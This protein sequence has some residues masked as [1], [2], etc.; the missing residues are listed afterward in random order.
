MFVTGTLIIIN[1]IHEFRWISRN[2]THICRIF[3]AMW[4]YFVYVHFEH[5]VYVCWL[6]CICNLFSP[7]NLIQYSIYRINLLLFSKFIPCTV[8]W[9]S[10]DIT[11]WDAHFTWAQSGNE[12][13]FYIVLTLGF[14]DLLNVSRTICIIE[15]HQF[16]DEILDNGHQISAAEPNGALCCSCGRDFMMTK[17]FDSH[18][19]RI[20]KLL[21]ERFQFGGI[22][23]RQRTSPIC[24]YHRCML[25]VKLNRIIFIVVAF[26]GLENHF[27]LFSIHS[28]SF[29]YPDIASDVLILRINFNKYSNASRVQLSTAYS[30]QTLKF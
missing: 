25:C 21:Y 1:V 22:C 19:F 2:C 15:F 12:N 26:W 30:E 10:H 14:T 7:I 4:S 28:I 13:M 9:K 16:D 23:D 17:I 29:C 11:I 5:I 24:D 3:C 8:Q 27:D 18:S 6:V 20:N